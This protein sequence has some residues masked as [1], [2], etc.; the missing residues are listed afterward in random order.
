MT[1]RTLETLIRLATAHAKARL[2]NRVEEKDAKAAESILRF[3]L[4]KEVIED[5]RRKRRKVSH[6]LGDNSS[7]EDHSSSD[8]EDGDLPVHRRGGPSVSARTPNRT[9]A[10]TSQSARQTRS[11]NGTGNTP[12]PTPNGRYTEPS[13]NVDESDLY[14]LSPRGL[15]SQQQQTQNSESQISFGSSQPASQLLGTQ[16]QTQ[17]QTQ[18]QSDEDEE[19]LVEPFEGISQDR[20]HLFQRMLGGMNTTLYNDEDAVDLDVLINAVNDRLPRGIDAFKEAEARLALE[21]MT[22]ENKIM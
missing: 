11:M 16:T 1:A 8:G 2:S 3:A 13:D 7:D 5:E 6:G 4:F 15:R 9:P 20:L 21:A 17:T 14:A 10:Q 22:D 19:E 18:N 12:T